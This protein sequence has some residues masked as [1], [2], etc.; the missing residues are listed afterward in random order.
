MSMDWA[1]IELFKGIDLNDSFVLNWTHEDNQLSFEL[2]ASIWPESEH[3]SKPK[4]D[5]YTCYRKATLM[6]T[7][8]QSIN[9]LKPIEFAPSTKDPDGITNYGNIDALYQTDNGFNIVGDFGSDNIIG[10]ELHFEVHT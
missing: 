8:V 7:K 9:G 10:G 6:F 3:Y 2:E 5:V 4:D 1:Q